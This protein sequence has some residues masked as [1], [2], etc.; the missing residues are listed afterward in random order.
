M[1]NFT[2]CMLLLILSGCVAKTNKDKKVDA[3]NPVKFHN[4]SPYADLLRYEDSQLGVVCYART[5]R[6]G[7]S[8]MRKPSKLEVELNNSLNKELDK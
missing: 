7:L 1:K 4:T 6:E 5:D 2:L 3:N 8:C